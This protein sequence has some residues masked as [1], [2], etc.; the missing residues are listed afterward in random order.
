MNQQPAHTQALTDSASADAARGLAPAREPTRDPAPG[1]A[2][3]VDERGAALSERV[4]P[5]LSQADG[6][7]DA[8]VEPEFSNL[9]IKMVP[10]HRAG[11][12]FCPEFVDDGNGLDVCGRCGSYADMHPVMRQPALAA[13]LEKKQWRSCD[14]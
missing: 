1:V 8:V 11:R 9:P 2:A 3:A 5:V 4:A 12:P 10:A 13:L 14:E 6:Y 7:S